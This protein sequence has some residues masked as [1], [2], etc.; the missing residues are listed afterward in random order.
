MHHVCVKEGLNENGWKNGE[1]LGITKDDK[2]S[3]KEHTGWFDIF[4][5]NKHIGRFVKDRQYG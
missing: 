2:F 1:K 5:N 4:V 3:I